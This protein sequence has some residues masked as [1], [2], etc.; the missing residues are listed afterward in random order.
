[1]KTRLVRVGNSQGVRIPKPLIEKAGLQGDLEIE[2][3]N[4]SL[5]IRSAKKSG[6]SPTVTTVTRSTR[7]K[8]KGD[9]VGKT[10]KNW[11]DILL[12]C[13]EKELFQTILSMPSE[14][15]DTIRSPFE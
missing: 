5:V 4:Q 15:T 14:S 8:P 10:S 2:V 6:R 9:A 12:A 7:Q 13:P 1:M 3:K 11:V